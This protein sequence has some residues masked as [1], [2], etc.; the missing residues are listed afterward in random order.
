MLAAG[1]RGLCDT[2]A[3][4]NR[5]RPW[6]H[7]RL[8]SSRTQDN[9]N[10]NGDNDNDDNDNDDNDNDDDDWRRRGATTSRYGKK[11][12]LVIKTH[13]GLEGPT[14][15]ESPKVS[16]PPSSPEAF[17][18]SAT[19]TTSRYGTWLGDAIF[20]SPGVNTNGMY[21]S[22][23]S[24]PLSF[25]LDHCI[26]LNL[27]RLGQRSIRQSVTI[28]RKVSAQRYHSPL[29]KASRGGGPCEGEGSHRLRS[30]SR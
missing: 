24:G 20:S 9:D 2:I 18:C 5:A 6:Q 3:V 29:R 4:G 13:G 1:L 26:R 11:R 23:C 12:H 28:L 16:E 30:E 8:T 27:P 15:G 14:P 25:P 21:R 19:A 17:R 7:R 22:L 10:D